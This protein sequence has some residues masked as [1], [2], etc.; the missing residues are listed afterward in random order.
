MVGNAIKFTHHG[1]IVVTASYAQQLGQL[2]RIKIEVRDSG[3]GISRKQQSLIFSRFGRLNPAWQGQ[4]TGAGLGLALVRQ[5]VTDLRGEIQVS[6]E[7]GKGSVFTCIL[8]LQLGSS[9]PDQSNH[10]SLAQIKPDTALNKT[11]TQRRWRILLVEDNRL[12][13]I[14]VQNQLTALNCDVNL[15][16][17]GEEALQAT[18]T[19][20]Y[21]LI[22]MDIGLPDINGCEVTCRI[23]QKKNKPNYH[24]PIV[25]LT[26]HLNK[27]DQQLCLDAGMQRVLIK[28]LQ[29]DQA[30]E[31]LSTL[32]GTQIKLKSKSNRR[33]L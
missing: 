28:P 13:Q 23:R 12:A 20:I 11:S 9:E 17:N 18:R 22:F 16:N 7:P 32:A 10:D 30:Y 3:I 31:V 25:A 15:V 6:S 29:T 14:A 19:T 26:A 33:K 2:T 5:F 1:E 27:E 4:Y 21:D 8:P 24:T